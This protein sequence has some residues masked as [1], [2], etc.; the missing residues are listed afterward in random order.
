MAPKVTLIRPLILVDRPGREVEYLGGFLSNLKYRLEAFKTDITANYDRYKPRVIYTVYEN[1]KHIPLANQYKE[2]AKIADIL[3]FTWETIYTGKEYYNK[4]S[5]SLQCFTT[6][7]NRYK[8]I[9]SFY[10]PDIVLCYNENCVIN[11]YE[12][13]SNDSRVI[14]TALLSG[15]FTFSFHITIVIIYFSSSNEIQNF[16]MP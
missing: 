3:G 2:T 8:E 13:P 16:Y 15:S 11:H 12:S 4:L 1:S 5:G 14:I 7:T 9:I 10:K 6:L